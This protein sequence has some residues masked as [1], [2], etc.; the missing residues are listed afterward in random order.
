[1]RRSTTGLSM[2]SLGTTSAG[3]GMS[4]LIPTTSSSS[5]SI[6]SMVRPSLR[7]IPSLVDIQHFLGETSKAIE[8]D[9]EEEEDEEGVDHVEQYQ[10]S[11]APSP[12]DRGLFINTN[13]E[14]SK[15][16]EEDLWDIAREVEGLGQEAYRHQVIME[17]DEEQHGDEEGGEET[18]EYDDESRT[19]SRA[20]STNVSR[21]VS[22]ETSPTTRRRNLMEGTFSSRAVKFSG[23]FQLVR[24]LLS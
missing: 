10:R 20:T 5:S 9:S 15:T 2:T 13:L 6:S 7:R 18:D 1:M 17:E 24:F 23:K 11:N 19:T 21:A 22:R 4:S 14:G 12:S 8:S 16:E 3:L